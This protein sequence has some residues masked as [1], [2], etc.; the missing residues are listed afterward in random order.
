MGTR[1]GSP[2]GDMSG[3]VGPM[4]LTSWKSIAVVKSLPAKTKKVSPNQESR[5]TLFKCVMQFLEGAKDVIKL[6]YQLPK[7]ATMSEMNMAASHHLLNAVVGEYPDYHIDLSKVKLS[8]PIKSTE[9]GWKAEFTGGKNLACE[10]SWELNPFPEKVTR[11]DDKAV[12]VVY[13][14]TSGR[15]LYNATNERSALSCSFSDLRKFEGHDIFS[16]LFFISADGRFV[17]ETKYLGMIKME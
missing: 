2:L 4:V 10:V 8:Q 15:F 17:S 3:K 16:W 5:R 11:R 1:S 13:D 12:A 6:G 14:S 7:K 9:N